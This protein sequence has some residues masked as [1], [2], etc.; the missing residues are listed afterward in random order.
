MQNV[1][2]SCF[3]YQNFVLRITHIKCRFLVYSNIYIQN[4]PNVFFFFFFLVNSIMLFNN[5]FQVSILKSNF[6]YPLM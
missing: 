3:H 5:Q 1:N 2:H 6:N 4:T